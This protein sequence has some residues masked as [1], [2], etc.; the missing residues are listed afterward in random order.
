MMYPN[1]TRENNFCR[2]FLMPVGY[3][4]GYCFGGGK[5]VTFV[6]VDWFHPIPQEDLSESGALKSWEEYEESLIA[7]LRQKQYVTTR[8]YPDS[9]FLVITNF[10][11]AF[12]FDADNDAKA[13]PASRKEFVVT[14]DRSLIA[15]IISEMLDS[16]DASG[17]YQTSKAFDKLESLVAKARAEV[18]E[19]RAPGEEHE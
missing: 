17:I 18:P 2:V 10:G 13:P 4:E 1:V 12:T 8:V 7:F 19:Q 5:P 16:A 11:K 9:S 14:S 3:P 6:M 15:H